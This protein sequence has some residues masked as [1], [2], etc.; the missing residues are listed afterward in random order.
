MPQKQLS[1]SNTAVFLIVHL[2][3][4]IIIKTQDLSDFESHYG[5]VCILFFFS[6]FFN[7]S[8]CCITEYYYMKILYYQLV[9]FRVLLSV[10]RLISNGLI[11]AT[12]SMYGTVHKFKGEAP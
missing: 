3:K 7:A 2:I 1:F 6:Y 4:I 9:P 12:E 8:S 5:M 10:P 11:F